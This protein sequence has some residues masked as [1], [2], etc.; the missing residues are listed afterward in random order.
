MKKFIISIMVFFAIVA[1]VDW[2]FGK[3]MDYMYL[4]AKGG[5]S[6]EMN[7]VCLSNKYDVLVMGSSRARHH[8]VPQI[9]SD[10]LGMSCYNTG[11]DGNGIILAY[12]IYQMA[13]ERYKPS[14]I[15][16]DVTKV[17][18]IY[19]NDEDQGNTRYVSMLKPYSRQSGIDDMF[20]SI[21]Y[22]EWIKT[23]SN[24]YRYNSSTF[25]TISNYALNI[26]YNSDGYEKLVSV[27]NYEPDYK[28]EPI[29]EIDSLKLW[30]FEKFIKDTK[31]KGIS[32]VCVL[33]PRYNHFSSIRYEPISK[34]CQKYDIP[35]LDY[36]YE[37]DISTNRDLFRDASHLND[38]GARAF[39][40]IMIRDVTKEYLC[41]TSRN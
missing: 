22:K 16:Y 11:K 33:S 3:G 1:G 8:Y 5:D 18:D 38:K 41:R 15:I 10:S 24:L 26:P 13:T 29:E 14:M 2:L 40:Q 27:M 4:H 34:L 36:Y 25:A 31:D 39:T 32:L 37:K 7:D 20:K 19:V 12:G 23:Y 6:K 21:S 30:Y 9:I 17:F 28:E 35:F